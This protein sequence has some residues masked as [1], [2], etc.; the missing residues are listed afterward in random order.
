MAL[1][2]S[3]GNPLFAFWYMYQALIKGFLVIRDNKIMPS[4]K[5]KK[6]VAFD[7]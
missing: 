4:V 2:L 6:A 3:Q 1:N 7:F 5:F